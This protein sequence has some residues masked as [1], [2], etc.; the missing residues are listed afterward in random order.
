M[1]DIYF[2]IVPLRFIRYYYYRI[3]KFKK[4]ILKTC[5]KK[6][7]EVI[8]IG[9][10]SDYFK[11]QFKKAKYISQDIKQNE[12][13]SIEIICDLNDGLPVKD[14]SFD[15][16]ICTQV[17]EHIKKPESAFKEFNRILKKGGKIFLTTNLCYEE[18]MIPHDYYRFTKYGLRY[19]GETNNFNLIHISPHGGIFHVLGVILDTIL[20]KLFAREG[21]FIYFFLI[22]VTVPL[23]LIYNV[24]FYFLDSL[25]R[26]K[27]WTINY[28]C[29]YQKK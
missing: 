8:D 15:F 2:K 10:Q 23:R 14:K 24:L 17:L 4:R 18:H 5:D 1:K 29:I 13:Q 6:G 22:A 21:S 20:I 26:K 25:D 16:I 19:L 28:E 9:A 7:K 3:D 12:D 27:A 11:R